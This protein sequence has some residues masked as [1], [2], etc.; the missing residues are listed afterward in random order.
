MSGFTRRQAIGA[1]TGVAAGT[2]LV[3]VATA[4]A[5]SAQPEAAAH[6]AKSAGPAPF[7][8]VYQ[9]RRIQGLPVEGEHHAHA[10]AGHGA[11]YRVLIDGRELHVMHHGKTGWSSS[12]NHYERFRTPLDAARTAVISLKGAAVVPFDPTV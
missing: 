12:I 11:T 7:D 4:T 9:G 3:G 2:A 8:E 6:G 5:D 10:R 1:V